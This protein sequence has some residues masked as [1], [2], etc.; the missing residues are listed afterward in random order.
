[1]GAFIHYAIAASIE[2]MAGAGF[3]LTAAEISRKACRECRHLHQQWHRRLLGDRTGT[4][5]VA[6]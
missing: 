6:Q 3:E 1:M 4:F 2:A 5:Q